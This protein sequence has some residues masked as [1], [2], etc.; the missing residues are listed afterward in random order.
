MTDVKGYLVIGV[1]ARGRSIYEHPSHP[2]HAHRSSMNARMS[3]SGTPISQR[4]IGIAVTPIVPCFRG[5]GWR[6]D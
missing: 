5:N 3:T 2:T 1:H 6:L 4:M